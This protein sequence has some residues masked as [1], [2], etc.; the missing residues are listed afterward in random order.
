[1]NQIKQLGDEN[2]KLALEKL[3]SLSYSILFEPL[4]PRA[5]S[6]DDFPIEVYL[7]NGLIFI[8]T[9]GLS[10][11]LYYFIY[12]EN[13]SPIS[14]T[15]YFIST[16]NVFVIDLCSL[17]TGSYTLHLLYEDNHYCGHFSIE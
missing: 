2:P 6:R 15:D 13:N 7:D 8:E 14:V 5:L 1:M 10:Q 16:N 3:D 4:H 9:N 17:P 12:D 11:N